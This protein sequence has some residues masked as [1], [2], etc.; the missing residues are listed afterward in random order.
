MKRS[1]FFLSGALQVAWVESTRNALDVLQ[2]RKRPYRFPDFFLGNPELVKR[3][4][5]KP[6]LGTCAKKMTEP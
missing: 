6:E 4:Q 2:S 5:V 1:T 3:L